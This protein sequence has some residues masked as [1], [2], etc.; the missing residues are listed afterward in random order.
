[1]NGTA[2]LF[3]TTE[4]R[5]A[6]PPPDGDGQE[7]APTQADSIRER[8]RCCCLP[9]QSGFHAQFARREHETHCH[10]ATLQYGQGVRGK[11]FP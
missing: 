10:V 9:G 6:V 5:L 8:G 2:Q 4:K 1:M 7:S 3:R 11:K